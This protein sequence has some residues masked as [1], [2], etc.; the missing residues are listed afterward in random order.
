MA[1]I[2]NSAPLLPKYAK[3]IYNNPFLASSIFLIVSPSLYPPLL[4]Q[5]AIPLLS[6]TLS[7]V[8]SHAQG[9]WCGKCTQERVPGQR[10]LSQCAVKYYYQHTVMRMNR[11]RESA[12]HFRIAIGTMQHQSV[13]SVGDAVVA[14]AAGHRTSGQR[15]RTAHGPVRQTG[16][17]QVGASLGAP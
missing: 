4:A 9:Q 14:A 5:M 15:S 2:P 6:S 1:G 8:E 11:R 13:R 3:I 12:H 16:S 10:Y 7:S 17:R